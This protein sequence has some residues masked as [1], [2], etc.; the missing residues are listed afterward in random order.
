MKNKLI[1]ISLFML[2]VGGDLKPS[3]HLKTVEASTG[4]LIQLMQEIPSGQPIPGGMTYDDL[5]DQLYCKVNHNLSSSGG[6]TNFSNYVNSCYVDDAMYLGESGDK[7]KIYVSGYEGWVDKRKANTVSLKFYVDA[8]NNL[9]PQSSGKGS[10]K[11]FNYTVY[12]TAEFIPVG[13]QTYNETAVAYSLEPQTHSIIEEIDSNEYIKGKEEFDYASEENAE[14]AVTSSARSGETRS[15]TVL[16]PSFY[17]K[18]KG[19]LVHYISKG[20]TRSNYYSKT[21]IGTAPSWM[22]EGQRYYSF[23]GVYFFNTI[24]AINPNGT[25][26][27]NQNNPFYNYYQFVPIRSASNLTANQIDAYTRS[28]GYTT[29]PTSTS[30]KATDSKL[31][32]AGSIFMEAQ[33]TYTINGAL[34]YAMG[35]H[36]SGFGRSKISVSKNNLF[37]MNAVD[38]DPS[39]QATG[40]ATVRDGILTH[41][42]KYLSWG[43][44][45]PVSDDRYYGFYLGNKGGGMNVKYASDPFWGEKIAAYYHRVDAANGKK[46][47][48]FYQLG[49][50]QNSTGVSV[51]AQPNSSSKEL[52]KTKNKSSGATIKHYPVIV[53]GES[54]DYYKIKTDTPIVNGSPSYSGTYNSSTSVGYVKK[55]AV[56]LVNNGRYTEGSV[57]P[58]STGGSTQGS[59]NQ[60]QSLI[61]TTIGGL[62]VTEGIYTGTITTDNLN[63]RDAAGTHGN[64]LGT[65]HLND[66]V[67]VIEIIQTSTVPWYKIHFG[68]KTGYIS[69]D[70]VQLVNDSVVA[71]GTVNTNT[72]N[73]RELPTA[74][75]SKLGTVSNGQTVNI[76]RA[77]AGYNGN[78]W[79][80]IQ[81]NNQIGYVS[82][83]YVD[84]KNT[85]KPSEVN[86]TL[87]FPSETLKVEIGT[88]P[89]FKQNV[90]VN[91]GTATNISFALIEDTYNPNQ[92]GKQTVKYV[93]YYWQNGVKQIGYFAREIE[94]I[95][96]VT[97]PTLTFSKETLLIDQGT[98][99]NFK[100]GVTLN[101]GTAVNVSYAIQPESFDPNKVGKQT[102]KYVIYY[103][104][105]QYRFETREVEVTTPPS[106]TFPKEPLVVNQGTTP[107]FKAGVTLQ[108]GTSKNVSYEVKAETFDPN[109]VGK[110]TVRYVIYYNNGRYR[111][112]DREV[113]VRAVIN[114]TLSFPK[115]TLKIPY[116]TTPNFKEGVQ[117]NAGTATNISFALIED[118][119]N[120][121]KVGKQT[122]KYVMY[123]WQNGVK[124]IASE[125]R[126]GNEY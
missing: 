28:K 21:T 19:E 29:V 80:K 104:N 70:Y 38:I 47:L 91:A 4:G 99:P 34:E 31:V 41:A 44:S 58:P 51:Y 40:F 83:D 71:T 122:V 74:E 61:G 43:Y 39:G 42:K 54:G 22:N 56:Q 27:V 98:T 112:V 14:V 117:V 57:T 26:A 79:L 106:L 59:S 12:T 115:E 24:E 108:T 49:M 82:S 88:T 126:N 100:E 55:S 125:C 67:E 2:L 87:I 89:N 6:V 101:K 66:K 20:I 69:S 3:D 25:G 77:V 17:T 114:P 46:D 36:E 37:G 1:P 52:Y 121:T 96:V 9:V 105:G 72:L 62:K 68:G 102:V 35:I 65:V 95:P 15:K 50:I 90:Q 63:V 78:I 85:T 113:E 116:G 73:V 5:K 13:S 120:P 92:L 33:K 53:I 109:K 86:P 45:D 23:D 8:N 97:P 123:Y 84:I 124:Q 107:D 119:Y 103:N 94:V 118:T 75:A 32:N 110:Q 111:F 60:D 16:S 10:W 30:L 48:D 64:V 76:L 93:M 18:E 81:Y 11:K 7:Y